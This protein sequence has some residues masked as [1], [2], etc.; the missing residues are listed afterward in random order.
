LHFLMHFI[1]HLLCVCYKWSFYQMEIWFLEYMFRIYRWTIPEIFKKI[2]SAKPELKIGKNVH[3]KTGVVSS[4][5]GLKLLTYPFKGKISLDYKP[6][7]L[8]TFVGQNS[9]KELKIATPSGK[10]YSTTR[11]MWSHIL[12]QLKKKYTK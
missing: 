7:N 8:Y 4:L 1:G 12:M 5:K 3:R 2:G 10:M 11:R 9:S 6:L